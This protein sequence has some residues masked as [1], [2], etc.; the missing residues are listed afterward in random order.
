MLEITEHPDRL[1][2]Q[3]DNGGQGTYTTLADKLAMRSLYITPLN[4][5]QVENLKLLREIEDAHPRPDWVPT[6]HWATEMPGRHA[7]HDLSPPVG[8]DTPIIPMPG[9]AA[10]LQ[11]PG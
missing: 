2:P 9:L 4:V 1:T 7:S 5:V 10:R 6:W 3:S 8:T 11:N